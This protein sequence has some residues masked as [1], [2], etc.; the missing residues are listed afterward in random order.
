MIDFRQVLKNPIDNSEMTE[1]VKGPDGLPVTAQFT[2]SRVCV[3]SLLGAIQNEPPASGEEQL[4]RWKLAKKIN[5]S[6][7]ELSSEEIS[8]IKARVA[9][10]YNIALIVGQSLEMLD[11]AATGA[12]LIGRG[13]KKAA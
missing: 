1:N 8:L 12:I 5:N 6:E 2:L 9:K 4:S 13:E 3:N 7:A 11:P 10:M